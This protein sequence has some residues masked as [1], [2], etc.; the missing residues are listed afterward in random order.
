MGL[1]L[2]N[3]IVYQNRTNGT[4]LNEGASVDTSLRRYY[5][6]IHFTVL[7]HKDCSSNAGSCDLCRLTYLSKGLKYSFEQLIATWTSYT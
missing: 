5:F 3:S 2:C 4:V 1:Q 7:F 6:C